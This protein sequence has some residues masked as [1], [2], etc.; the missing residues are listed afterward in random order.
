[1]VSRFLFYGALGALILS[2][3]VP[4]LQAEPTVTEDGAVVEPEFNQDGTTKFDGFIVVGSNQVIR[5]GLASVADK[6][7]SGLAAISGDPGREN[8]LPIIIQ[9]YGAEG[10]DEHKRS[11]VSQIEQLQGKYHLKLHIHLAKGVDHDLL[12][13]HLMEMLLYE[14]GLGAGQQVVEG[15][16]V[17]VKPWLVLGLLEALDVKSGQVDRKIYQVD[18][19][20][21]EVLP[22]QKVFD[23]SEVDWRALDGRRPIAF[24]A[25]SGA[26]VN[27]LL[28]QPGGRR[29]MGEYLADVATFKGEEEN[30]MRKHFPSM[31]KSR[32]SLEKWVDLE[33]AELGTAKVTQV[34]SLLETENRLESV[35]RL[36]Y[37]DEEQAAVSVGIDGYQE[38][39]ELEKP[40]RVAAVAG[41]SAELERLSYRCF[42]SYR[43]LI[44]EYEMIL[45]ELIVGEDEGIQVRLNKL[46]DVRMKSLEIGKRSRDYLDWFYITQSNEVSGDFKHYREL[47]EAVR[48]ESLKTRADDAT[49]TYLEK[50]Q[51]MYGW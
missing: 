8:A 40:D 11:V 41:A 18:M 24:R 9:L 33:M 43:P 47:S 34:Y 25:I 39:L 21:F 6:M 27:A 10:D 7:R 31:N 51:K 38:I 3:A 14:R 13:Y 4:T 2:G 23:S 32:N 42:P 26:M 1:M 45:R 22:V 17:Q 19:P 50:V 49:Q 36:R 28:R 48:K 30:L 5:G 44:A 46:G 15:E 16:H 29:G 37:R 12:R 35:L 20:Y